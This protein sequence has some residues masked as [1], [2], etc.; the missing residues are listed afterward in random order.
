M[1]Y[2]ERVGARAL[3]ADLAFADDGAVHVGLCVGV[4]VRGACGRVG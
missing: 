1:L 3:V 4:D 2:P